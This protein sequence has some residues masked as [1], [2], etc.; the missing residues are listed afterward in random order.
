MTKGRRFLNIIGGLVMLAMGA[1]MIVWPE[2]GII[3]AAVLISMSYTLRGFNTMLYYFTMAR[4]MVGGRRS[5]FTGMFY[6]DIGIL[7]S[8]LT[9]GATRY[10]ALYLAVMH[11]FLGVVGILRSREEKT[12]NSPGWK[13]TV[14]NSAVNIAIAICVI[15]GGI[16]YASV[17]VVVYIYAAGVIYEAIARIAGAFRRTAIVYIQ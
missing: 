12:A 11:A 17:R 13:W 4:N 3:A 14:M 7:T 9:M 1:L 8:A 6:L 15:I 16:A 5:L 10:L 2:R